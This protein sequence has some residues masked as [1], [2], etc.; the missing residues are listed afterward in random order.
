MSDREP[1]AEDG[2][3]DE[4]VLGVGIS[5]AATREEVAALID[6][7][8]AASAVRTAAVR[9]VATIDTRAAHPALRSLA[10]PVMAYRDEELA[11]VPV[12]TPSATVEEHAGTPS[13]AEAGA[14][15]AAGPG[16]ELVLAKRTRAHVT[17]AIARIHHPNPRT[18]QLSG[19]KSTRTPDQFAETKRS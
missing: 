2:Y 10:W 17:V 3:A 18:G 11:E 16:S 4:Y 7:A 6:D 9:A 14:L 13:V 5:S 12:P 15:L 1:T 8:L 19:S